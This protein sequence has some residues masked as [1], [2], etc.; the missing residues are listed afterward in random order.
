MKCKRKKCYP[1]TQLDDNDAEIFADSHRLEQVL[2]NLISNAIKFTPEGG[3]ID[4]RTELVDAK[5]IKPVEMFEEELKK[6]RGKYLQG[7]R[8]R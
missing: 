2:T 1:L 8:E 3:K 4:I 7:L 5:D 6:L